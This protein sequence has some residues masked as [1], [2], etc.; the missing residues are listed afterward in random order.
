M[1]KTYP[2]ISERVVH[3]HRKYTLDIDASN[4][5]IPNRI[6]GRMK[7]RSSSVKRQIT[8]PHCYIEHQPKTSNSISDL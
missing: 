3:K 1:H 5:A 6:F 4:T 8:C 7:I 2:L